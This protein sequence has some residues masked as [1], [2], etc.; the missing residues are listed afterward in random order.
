[1]LKR[2]LLPLIR[3]ILRWPVVLRQRW[4]WAKDEVE[5]APGTFVSR[6]AR[7]GRRVRIT[8]PSYID[9]CEIGPYSILARV[10]IRSV[11][12]ETRF[13]NMQE[14]AQRRV[15]GGRS[16]VT[17]LDQPIRI[18]AACWLSDNVTVLRGVEIGNGAV[19][20]AGAVVTKDVPPFA[21]A[22]G[23]PARVLRY[24]YP[25]EIVD[26]IRDVDWWNWSDERLRANADLFEI[27]LETVEPAVLK[28]RIAELD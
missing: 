27:D 11:N 7:L 19:I 1:M 6:G 9:P 18:G 14:V 5:V 22:V 2:L 8:T 16:V 23:N 12:H 3:A 24:R 4:Q 20:G 13:L 15:I 10:S 17:P 28:A 26:L 25:D 21:I